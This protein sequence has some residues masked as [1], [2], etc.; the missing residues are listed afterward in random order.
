M[1]GSPRRAGL[2]SGGSIFN[3]SA[4]RSA[5]NRLTA[6]NPGTA[7]ITASLGGQTNFGSI[8]VVPP[9]VAVNQLKHRYSFNEAAGSTTA[10]DSVGTAHAT[11]VPS[12][13]TT[14]PVVI[15]NGMARFPGLGAN[16]DFE[17]MEKKKV[18]VL[19]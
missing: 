9:T 6:V 13:G 3:T 19:S 16:I 7:T 17:L 12:L 14:P 10:N 2:P 4:P 18:G 11:V 8:T 5:N 15:S 1:L